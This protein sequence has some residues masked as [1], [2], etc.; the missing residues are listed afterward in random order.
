MQK[1][2]ALSWLHKQGLLIHSF[3]NNQKLE[4]ICFEKVSFRVP[5]TCNAD[6]KAA[7]LT[8]SPKNEFL[9]TCPL[10]LESKGNIPETDLTAPANVRK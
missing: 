4:S 2:Q 8:N 6:G 3:T 1:L 10:P 7:L 5:S 9:F